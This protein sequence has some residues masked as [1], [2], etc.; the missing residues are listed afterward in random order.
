MLENRKYEWRSA[1]ENYHKRATA[2]SSS[3]RL[4]ATTDA[5]RRLRTIVVTLGGE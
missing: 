3:S 1:C 5:P 2:A 4:G